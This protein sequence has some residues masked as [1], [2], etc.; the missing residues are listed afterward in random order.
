MR[1]RS[2]S[3]HPSRQNAAGDKGFRA[4]NVKTRTAALTHHRIIRSLE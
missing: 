2:Q 1:T 3:K 4:R